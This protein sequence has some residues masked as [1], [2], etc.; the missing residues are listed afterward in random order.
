MHLHPVDILIILLYFAAMIG[1]GA[2]LMRRASKNLDSYFLGSHSLPWWALGLS[3]ASSMWDIA[4]TMWLV[5]N[6][7]IYGMKGTWLPYLWPTFNQI[8]L[9][10]FLARWIRRS[11]VLTGAEWI[12]TRFSNPR[13]VELSR[14]IIVIFAL[15]SV[16]AFVAYAFQGIGK[17]AQVFLP[18]DWQPETY[19]IVIMS[20]TALYVLLGGMLSVVITDLIQFFIM[21]ICAVILAA[22]AMM[23]VSGSEIPAFVPEGWT[24]LGFGWEL[25]LDWSGIIPA[26]NETVASDGYTLFGLFFMAMLC[27][28]ILVSIAG[29]APNYDMQRILAA[30]SPHEAGLMSGVVSIALLPRWLLIAAITLI[31]L[32]Y[33]GPRFAAADPAYLNAGGAIDF[34]MVLPFV[35]KEFVPVGLAGLLLSGLLAAF[36]STFSST[37]NAGGAYLVN[38]LYK[39]YIRPEASSRH[40]I[41][42]SYSAQILVLLIGFAV[43]FNLSSVDQITKWIVNGLFGGYTAANILKWYWWR[44]NGIGYFVGMVVGIAAAIIIPL[45]VFPDA[46]SLGD[47][48]K[49]FPLILGLSLAAT[50]LASLLCPPED[51]QTLLAFY[52]TVRPWGFWGPVRRKVQSE[53]PA[54]Q[55]ASFRRDATNVVVGII[56]QIPLWTMPVYFVLREWQAFAISVGVF[57]ATS[58]FL[59]FNWL[60]PMRRE[61]TAP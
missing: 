17:F 39:R 47:L 21:G 15:V 48:L 33:L 6:L 42:A 25:N 8:V 2:W 44:L 40:L 13:G 35:I 61:E 50:I 5:S 51:E 18:F 55:P 52:R 29:P 34:E 30:R 10:V 23:Q 7:F 38:D 31:G 14:S 11:N 16:V 58:L 60:D 12:S 36:M 57:L 56:W 9:M 46:D 59:K 3:N 28:G 1:V 54:F 24:H 20:I 27:K 45:F 53:S 32:K 37:L 26:L 49:S 19:A 4:G 41:V 43:G 22:I